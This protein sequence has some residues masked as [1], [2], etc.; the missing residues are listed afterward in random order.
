VA[1]DEPR[2]DP[3]DVG[4]AIERYRDLAKY[5]ITIFAAVGALLA[6]GTQLSALGRLSS[7]HLDRVA[8][9]VAGLLLAVGAIV[10]VIWKA[11]GVLKPVELSFDDVAD[12]PVLSAQLNRRRSLLGGAESVGDVRLLLETTAISEEDR[13]GWQQV[14]D[15]LVAHA[16]FLRMQATFEA[17]W[18]PLLL[19]A[20]CGVIGI[21][22]FAWG[23][24]PPAAAVAP[25]AVRP[26]P[27]SVR[28]SLT[29]DGREA[30]GD[31]LGGAACAGGPIPALS[32]GG[33]E[34]E[35]RVVTL[36]RTGCKPAQFVL[37]ADWGAAAPVSRAPAK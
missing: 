12:D 32:I 13:A 27:V 31:A 6:A 26:A 2:P 9:A 18:K 10:A 28:V 7:D 30:L 20:L 33:K 16:A 17:A 22:A 5:L 15:D 8:A 34:G 19:A 29:A 24:N 37:V 1:A 14:A 11:L 21:C 23:A 3:G 4:S 35:P 36:P 25:A